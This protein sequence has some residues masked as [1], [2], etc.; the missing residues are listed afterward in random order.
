ME[1][2][3]KVATLNANIEYIKNKAGVQGVELVFEELKKRGYPQDLRKMKDLDL[4]PVDMRKELLFVVRDVLEW[5][6]ERIR[7]MGEQAVK[8][9]YIMRTF[10]GLFMNMERIFNAAPDIWDKNYTVGK[11]S[12]KVDVAKGEGF[13]SL[14]D[15]ELDP[16]VCNYLLGYFTG[17]AKLAKRTN[18]QVKEIKCVHK[19]DDRHEF[20]ITWTP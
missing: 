3:C 13:V 4:V 5:D 12:S 18:L 15:F 8:S 6:D 17:V 16:L 10:I 9:S 1:G 20:F 2:S 14:T 11:M 7:D 19:G